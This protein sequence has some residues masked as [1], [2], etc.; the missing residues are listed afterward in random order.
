MCVLIYVL[1]RGSLYF[2]LTPLQTIFLPSGV[3]MIVYEGCLRL[4]K[5]ISLV[6]AAGSLWSEV[7]FLTVCDYGLLVVS[8]TVS[9]FCSLFDGWSWWAFESVTDQRTDW[10]TDWSVYWFIQQKEWSCHHRGLSSAAIVLSCYCSS[11]GPSINVLSIHLSTLLPKDSIHPAF[12]QS[13]HLFTAA[14]HQP[15]CPLILT[16]LFVL[17]SVFAI[18]SCLFLF[19]CML[20]GS[21]SNENLSCSALQKPHSIKAFI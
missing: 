14:M 10:L 15:I 1:K 19:I 2:W 21:V 7:S 18:F 6:E 12:H 17:L 8:H 4:S 11:V 13:I 16:F 3:Q 5:P 20:W 9:A